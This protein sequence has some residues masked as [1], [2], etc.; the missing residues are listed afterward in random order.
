MSNFLKK[1]LHPFIPSHFHDPVGLALRLIRLKDPAASF[2]MKTTLL[3]GVLSPLDLLL[4]VAEK[5]CYQRA[6]RP[7]LP[8]IFV[9]GP[10]RSGTTLVAQ[11]LIKSLPVCYIN[12]LTAVFPRSPVVANFLFG[13]LIR[14]KEMRYES[15]Y[16]KSDHFSGPNDGLYIWDRWIGGR[17]RKYIRP[18]LSESEKDDMVRFFG[19]YQQAFQR[20]LVNKNNSLN[21][22]ASLIADIFENSYFICMTRD[23]MYLAQALLIARIEIHGNV[24]TAY[25]VDDPN[26]SKD[27]SIDYVEDVCRQVLFHEQQSREQL[28]T[29][30][31]E[32]FWIIS[33]EK[34]CKKPEDLVR[35]VS[36]QILGQPIQ[37]VRAAL[38]P[39]EISSRIKVDPELF[40][41]IEQTLTCVL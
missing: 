36:E 40:K 3:G 34:F 27:R 16:G 30:G 9:C 37:K 39:F 19:A 41:K 18:S 11:V 21:V 26:K 6:P 15:Y 12:N 29:V 17:D 28:Q 10:P 32:R 14:R 5:R 23:P 2:A 31:P 25:G 35:R 20:P 4:Q 1:S 38:K 7:K 13:K 22:C 33:Y 8:L 24:H